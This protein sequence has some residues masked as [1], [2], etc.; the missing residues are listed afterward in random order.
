MEKVHVIC[1]FWG[2]S[3]LLRAEVGDNRVKVVN[4][5]VGG[6]IEFNGEGD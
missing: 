3:L 5:N 2:V 1:V 6:V 4:V